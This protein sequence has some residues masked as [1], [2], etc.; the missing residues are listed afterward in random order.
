MSRHPPAAQKDQLTVLEKKL[1]AL[2]E[3]NE[4][5]KKN[6]YAEE[7]VSKGVVSMPPV[8]SLHLLLFSLR[9]VI[10]PLPN[11]EVIFSTTRELRLL[12]YFQ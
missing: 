3:E 11:L 4:K 5:L 12:E 1:Q 8:F 7:V 9:V 6:S 2:Q 10:I